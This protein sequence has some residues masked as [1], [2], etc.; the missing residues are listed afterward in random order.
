MTSTRCRGPTKAWG[1]VLGSTSEAVTSSALL[2]AI[3]PALI[4]QLVGFFRPERD[5]N[6]RYLDSLSLAVPI[7]IVLSNA[8]WLLVK[9]RDLG[10]RARFLDSQC[11]PQPYVEAQA[12]ACSELDSLFNRSTTASVVA[13]STLAVAALS[14]L[15]IVYRVLRDAAATSAPPPGSSASTAR[16]A[17][18]S[19][20]RA[21]EPAKIAALSILVG[22]V[23]VAVCQVRT[24]AQTYQ[25]FRDSSVSSQGAALLG[26]CLVVP[27]LLT[28]AA[29]FRPEPGRAWRGRGSVVACC[30]FVLLPTT[31]QQILASHDFP[32]PHSSAS[33]MSL[34][35]PCA[36]WSGTGFAVIIWVLR[37]DLRPPVKPRHRQQGM[38]SCWCR[39]PHACSPGSVGVPAEDAAASSVSLDVNVIEPGR[40]EDRMRQWA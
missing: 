23:T 4:L 16:P 5:G 12:A 33:V 29:A 25:D 36:L 38:P 34:L 27:P 40:V 17:A 24:Y 11:H 15:L 37:R 18:G 32:S 28:W 39:D 21:S 9:S 6:Y 31:C 7:L 8:T 14:S 30:W 22:V 1:P 20:S 35:V 13:S 26:G 19:N 3:V 10:E 2:A